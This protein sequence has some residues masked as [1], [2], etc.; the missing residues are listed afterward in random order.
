MYS[1]GMLFLQGVFPT[2]YNNEIHVE[3]N[4]KEYDKIPLVFTNIDDWIKRTNLKCWF[5]DR[6]HSNMPWFEPHTVNLANDGEIGNIVPSSLLVRKS[7]NKKYQ[8]GIKGS[9]CS[10]NCVA[11]YIIKNTYNIY[12][13]HN[14]LAMLLLEYEALTDKVITEIIPSPDKTERIEYGGKLSDIEYQKKIDE[15]NA[16]IFKDTFSDNYKAFVESTIFNDDDDL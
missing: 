16:K 4:T 15:S 8:F 7:K 14:K 11:A 2:E 9:F 6:Q 10:C 3:N 1:K 5:C 13:R 12:D